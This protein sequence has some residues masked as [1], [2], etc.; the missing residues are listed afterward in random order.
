MYLWFD[1]CSKNKPG[2]LEYFGQGHEY[3]GFNF[4]K[5]SVFPV[6]SALVKEYIAQYIQ[7][8]HLGDNHL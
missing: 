7:R 2:G 8:E 3:V 4:V 1:P 6:E 5:I